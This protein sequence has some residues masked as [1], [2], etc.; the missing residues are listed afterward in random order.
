MNKVQAAKCF[1]VSTNTITEWV[2]KGC[3]CEKKGRNGDQYVFD[4]PAIITWRV[5]QLVQQ[6]M[7]PLLKHDDL[8]SAMKRE[9]FAKAELRELE[10]A[11]KR[12]TLINVEAASTIVTRGIME[13][14]SQL[15]ALPTKLAPRLI[16]HKKPAQMRMALDKAVRDALRGVSSI[17]LAED[18]LEPHLEPVGAAA[19]HD[20]QRVG[21]SKTPAQSRKQRRDRPMGNQPGR[22]PARD[23]GRLQRSRGGGGRGDELGPNRKDRDDQ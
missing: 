8:A 15:L 5:E 20:G 7:G 11:E 18:I 21:G 22:I 4:L 19:G 16:V 14:R 2:R 17:Q 1:R 9:A 10:L 3:P 13:T 23:H 12:K 6:A